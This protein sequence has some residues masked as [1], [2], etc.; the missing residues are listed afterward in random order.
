M[1]SPEFAFLLWILVLIVFFFIVRSF[2]IKWW[3]SLVFAFLLAWIVLIAV[4]PWGLL[5]RWSTGTAGCY[6]EGLFAVI[7]IVTIVILIIYIIQRVFTDREKKCK[8]GKFGKGCTC[9]KKFDDFDKCECGKD[10]CDG[11]CGKKFI[12]CSCGKDDCDGE[13]GKKFGSYF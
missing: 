7:T 5:T 13:C 2:C 4:F 11:E 3:P 12:K 1:I 8:C 10:D 9:N 6:G